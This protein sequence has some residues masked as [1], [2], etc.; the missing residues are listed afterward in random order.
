MNSR[1]IEIRDFLVTEIHKGSSAL[2]RSASQKFS[3]SRQAIN[4]YLRA[5]VD[6]GLIEAHGIT[7]N[8]QYSLKALT[9]ESLGVPLSSDLREDK[10]WRD[11]VRPSLNDVREN[12][13][14]ICQYGFTEIL[15][16]AIDHSEG[17]AAII[18]FSRTAAEIR[19][20]IA[21]DGV[22]IFNK[23]KN[24]LY[25]EDE[26]HAILELSKGKLTTDPVKHS[27]EGIFFTSRVFDN[28]S[29][30]SGSLFFS[31]APERGDWLLEDKVGKTAPGTYVVMSISVY[32]NRTL[33]E[34]FDQYASGNADYGFSRTHIPVFLARY[35]D[36][37]LVS[38]SQAKRL[39]NRLERFKEI[40]FDFQGV[41]MI[42]QAFADE[43][44]RV[45]QHE[46]P[47]SNLAW[48]NT[49]LDVNQ[50]IRRARADIN[51]QMTS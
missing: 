25:L 31:Y 1:K 43:I 35:G 48:I 7:K 39:L 37:N 24:E 2:V 42:G 40:V 12:V 8:R 21:D 18:E 45:F 9:N 51:P 38:R 19:L 6:E 26:R 15:N 41:G 47:E 34:V 27:G 16:N 10:V 13:I 32:S 14:R 22:G 29:I 33:K 28:F 46:H 3:I 36:E 11:K 20:G 49:N 17:K 44:F 4:R 30:L 5:M 23:I 50:M